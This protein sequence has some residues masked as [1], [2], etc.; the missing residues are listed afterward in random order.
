MSLFEVSNFPCPLHF[1]PLLSI[2]RDC[3]S[4]FTTPLPSRPTVDPHPLAPLPQ[5]SPTIGCPAP[6]AIFLGHPSRHKTPSAPAPLVSGKL[7]AVD[8]GGATSDGRRKGQSRL[9]DPR[10]SC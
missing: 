10:H 9:L 5:F 1:P 7:L 6:L 8:A 3:L 2:T 4:E